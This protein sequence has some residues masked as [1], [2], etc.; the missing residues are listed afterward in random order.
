M[1]VVTL[2]LLYKVFCFEQAEF[3]LSLLKLQSLSCLVAYLCWSPVLDWARIYVACVLSPLLAMSSE[4]LER[5]TI[6]LN[7][8]LADNRLVSTVATLDVHHHCDRH[9]TCDPLLC[10]CCCVLDD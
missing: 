2:L 4:E 3:L 6:E 5:S 8:S 9:T 7:K 10:R 1:T